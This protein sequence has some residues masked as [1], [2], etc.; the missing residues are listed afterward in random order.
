MKISVMDLMEIRKELQTKI[1]QQQR[2]VMSTPTTRTVQDGV[3]TSQVS[4]TFG[5]QFEKLKRLLN[6]SRETNDVLARFNT[7]QG[8]DSLVRQKKNLEVLILQLQN[9]I[10]RT[11][12]SSGV[13]YV[14]VGSERVE[15]VTATK[16]VIDVKA[17]E[18][19]IRGYKKE[20]SR[21]QA[22][23]LAANTL[24]VEVSFSEEDL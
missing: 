5:E 3:V 21:I 17:I 7:E 11:N 24:E 14:V 13:Q 9:A 20:I 2:I 6:F 1:S 10:Q 16:A 15:V 22:A 23:I 8:V 4:T 18:K 19:E 12:E